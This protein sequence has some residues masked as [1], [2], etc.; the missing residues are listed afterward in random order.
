MKKLS[1]RDGYVGP[2][3]RANLH[4]VQNRSSRN[5]YRKKHNNWRC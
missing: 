5:I 1:K 2:R 3:E 4:R